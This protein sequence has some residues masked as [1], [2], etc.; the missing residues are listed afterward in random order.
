MNSQRIAIIPARGGSKRI[1]GKNIRPF[2]GKPIIAYS[3]ETALQSG[4]FDE[5]MVSTDS[6]DIATVA[7]DYKA[8]VPF[9]RSKK[10]SDDHAV[11]SDVI[12]EVLDQY[13]KAGRNFDFFCCIFPTAPFIKKE[14]LEKGFDLLTMHDYD[15]VFPVIRFGYPILRSL[16]M[17]EGKVSMFWPEYLNARSQDLEPAFHDAGQ[18]YWMRTSKFLEQGRIF[19]SNSG[20]IE[21]NEMEMH[22][23]DHETDWKLAEMKYRLLNS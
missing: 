19:A 18:F 7:R 11:V 3:I 20:A 12:A 8:N 6:E 1:P 22:D 13:Q 16:R 14:H 21:M 4:L 15:S 9:F 17:K 23:I 10:T 2:L 5:V